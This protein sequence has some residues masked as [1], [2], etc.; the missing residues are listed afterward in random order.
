MPGSGGD[1][2]GLAQRPEPVQ[3]L[4]LELAAALLADAEPRADLGV[5]L[6]F[7]AAQSVA[8]QENFAM[9]VRQRAD[10]RPQLSVGLALV[11][12]PPG[13]DGLAVGDQVAE[14]GSVLPHRLIE[15]RGHGG[16]LAQRVHAA[17][18]EAGA[19]GDRLSRW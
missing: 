11:G 8:A 19:L 10:D 15:R 6:G 3:C 9:A 2:P 7:L 5:R 14:R 1:L 4:A 17:D 12:V 16:G 18:A 13:V